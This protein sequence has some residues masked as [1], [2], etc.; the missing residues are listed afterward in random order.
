MKTDFMYYILDLSAD[1]AIIGSQYPQV[2]KMKAGYDYNALNAADKLSRYYQALPE[3]TPNMDSFVLHGHAKPTDFLS[4]ALTGPW[5]HIVSEKVK[6]IL[7]G[8]KLPPVHAFYPIQMKYRKGELHGYYWLHMICDLTDIVDYRG[9]TFYV[10]NFRSD[11]GGIKVS[12]REDLLL[13]REHL[14][15][16]LGDIGITICA[17]KIKL[18][19]PVE[20]DFF[21]VGFFDSNDYITPS[22]KETLEQE[23][24]TGITIKVSSVL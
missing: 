16:D 23:G 19:H 5:G 21:S 10:K 15:E 22:L 6:H 20:Y 9:S 11:L 3:F 2:Q 1:T 14:K 24:A 18:V 17:K 7:E 4:S 13:K 8:F 12:S